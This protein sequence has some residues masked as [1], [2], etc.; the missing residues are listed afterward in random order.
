MQKSN[1]QCFSIDLCFL[2]ISQTFENFIQRIHIFTYIFNKRLIEE[3]GIHRIIDASQKKKKII[4]N[5]V[6][7]NDDKIHYEIYDF[8]KFFQEYEK[9]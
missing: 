8:K 4:V 2:S 7:K 1:E 3:R 6:L 5:H 9:F